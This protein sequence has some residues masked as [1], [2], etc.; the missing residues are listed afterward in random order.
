MEQVILLVTQSTNINCLA[1]ILV[2]EV[3]ESSEREDDHF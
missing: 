2:S 3:T 1:E